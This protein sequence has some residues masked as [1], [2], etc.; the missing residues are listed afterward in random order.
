MNKIEFKVGERYL[1]ANGS[2]VEIYH[3]EQRLFGDIYFRVIEGGLNKDLKEGERR[4][5]LAG[6]STGQIY[7]TNHEGVY[8]GNGD[9]Y[10]AKLLAVVRH[11]NVLEPKKKKVTFN[12]KSEVSLA[13]MYELED[14]E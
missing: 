12:K 2:I 7:V 13:S 5:C 10:E 4:V 14:E 1:T 9:N 3:I 11:A 6:S 8:Y